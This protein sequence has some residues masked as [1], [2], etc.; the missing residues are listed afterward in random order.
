MT[1]S[2]PT[3]TYTSGQSF[4]LVLLA[5]PQGRVV[6]SGTVVF[7]GIDVTGF[8]VG[9]IRPGAAAGGMQSF[10]CPGIGGPIVGPGTHTLQ[11]QLIMN[12]GSLVQRSVTWT[13]VPVI[14][15]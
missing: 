14:E 2:P 10:R 7:N 13:V 1:L 15:P 8:I 5:D 9:C 11:V 4:D 3:G 12:D 6:T